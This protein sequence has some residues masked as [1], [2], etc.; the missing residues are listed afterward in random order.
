[1]LSSWTQIPQ[2]SQRKPVP[3]YEHASALMTIGKETSLYVVGG[4]YSEFMS[5]GAYFIEC[6]GGVLE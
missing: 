4:N 3:R 2:G 6:E 1:M 5:R